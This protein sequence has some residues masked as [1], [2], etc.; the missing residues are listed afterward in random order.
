MSQNKCERSTDL[1]T[2]RWPG[3][4]RDQTE[5]RFKTL[6]LLSSKASFRILLCTVQPRFNRQIILKLLYRKNH[7]H[8][9]H[10]P[11]GFLNGPEVI[12]IPAKGFFF[13]CSELVVIYIRTASEKP[14]PVNS[15]CLPN[16]KYK[17]Y[18]PEKDF[19][20]TGLS[21]IAV[22]VSTHRNDSTGSNKLSFNIWVAI[23]VFQKHLSCRVCSTMVSC[24]A[25]TDCRPV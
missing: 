24:T 16:R 18:Q 11:G 7:C 12:T 6:R 22:R 9:T 25:G 14:L 23:P 20:Q 1:H 21:D 19:L 17:E 15:C 8:L 5:S 13:F 10:Q 4:L 2:H 3:I